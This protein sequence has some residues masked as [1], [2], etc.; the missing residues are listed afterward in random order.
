VA[1]LRRGS[2][3]PLLF[4]AQ[5]AERNNRR[6]KARKAIQILCPEGASWQQKEHFKLFWESA[7]GLDWEFEEPP[8][9]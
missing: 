8:N 7:S 2:G 1:D 4:A 5:R 6:A 9:E 3:E